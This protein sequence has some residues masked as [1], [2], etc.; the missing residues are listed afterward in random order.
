MFTA[1]C[2]HHLGSHVDAMDLGSHHGV[3]NLAVKVMPGN[4][5]SFYSPFMYASLGIQF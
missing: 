3:G 4:D 5:L 2:I 1:S